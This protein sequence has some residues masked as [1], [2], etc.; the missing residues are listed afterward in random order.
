MVDA[1]AVQAIRAQRPDA[2]V[3]VPAPSPTSSI[4]NNHYSY[5]TI[6]QNA[7][8]TEQERPVTNLYVTLEVDG[9]TLAKAS[10]ERIDE[11]QG[12]KI[13]LITRGVSV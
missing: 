5:N 2:S 1:G 9:E 10:A 6:N 13:E 8:Q 11:K 4:I 3:A 12:E 7:S